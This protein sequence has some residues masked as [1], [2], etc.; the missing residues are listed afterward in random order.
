MFI[1]VNDL[2][3]G[4]VLYFELGDVVFVDGIFIGGYNVIC[5]EF[6]VMGE[7]DVFF[8]IGGVEVFI[9]LYFKD[10][11]YLDF[12]IIFGFRVMEGEILDWLSILKDESW[13][14]F[15]Y[16]YIFLYICWNI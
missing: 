12:F 8:K 5:D 7:F 10:N 11:D 9:V 16:G 14:I 13:L 15:R 6:F 3:V 1:N 4:D 2:F